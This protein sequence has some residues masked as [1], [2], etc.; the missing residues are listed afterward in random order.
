MPTAFPTPVL[1]IDADTVKDLE[2]RDAL[3]GLWTCKSLLVNIIHILIY[4]STPSSV[5]EM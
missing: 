5:Y 3:L 2:G 4:I 1:S